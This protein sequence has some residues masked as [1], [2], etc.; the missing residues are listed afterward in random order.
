MTALIGTNTSFTIDTLNE[1][2]GFSLGDRMVDQNGNEYVFVQA[3]ANIAQYDFVGIDEDFQAAPLS[4]AMA[5]DGWSIGIAQIAFT[6]NDYGWVAI[7]GHGLEGNVLADCALDVALYT[8]GTAGKL[9]DDTTSQ[10]KIEGLVAIES[11]GTATSNVTMIATW[12]R[13]AGF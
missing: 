8:S 4:K 6:D 1:G 13:S 5:D 10:T 7:R 11:N 12:P 3:S 2:R 9:D